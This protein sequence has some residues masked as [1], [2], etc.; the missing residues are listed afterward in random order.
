MANGQ[1]IRLR[2]RAIRQTLQVTKAMGLISTAK[3]R[4]AKRL[5]EN[6]E[7]FFTRIQKSLY[8]IISSAGH[9]QSEF[10]SKTDH[11]RIPRSAVLLISS[12]KGMAGGYNAN[13]FRTVNELCLQL[14]NPVLLPVG[15]IG[16]RYC[17]HAPYPM[18]E[19]FSFQSQMPTVDDARF[20]ADYLM[21]QYLWGMFDE[22]HVVYTHMYSMIKIVPTIRQ[23]LPLS[24]P[25]IQ[26]EI[27]GSGGQERVELQFEYL[28]SPEVVFEALVPLYIR[29]IIYGCLVEAYASEQNTRMTAMNEASENA[30]K[31]LADL[32]IYYNRVRQASIT[33]E[34]S[35]IVGGSTALS[36]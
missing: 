20:V 12:D 25:K 13:I 22:I 10:I 29:G 35:E 1:E 3:L 24:A 16:Y 4:K 21:S 28:P 36:D 18:I 11:S 33:Q 8:D 31:M 14:K 30:E 23:I 26:E 9:V 7:P 6:T 19:N 17:A 5:L 2:M 34:M 32:Q 15:A 27:T